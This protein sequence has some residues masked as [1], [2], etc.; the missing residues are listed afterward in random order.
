MHYTGPYMHFYTST[1]YLIAYILDDYYKLAGPPIYTQ[2]S[3]SCVHI[4]QPKTTIAPNTASR[5]ISS[6]KNARR[7]DSSL[8]VTNP[9]GPGNQDDDH[10]HLV[11]DLEALSHSFGNH[12]D[13][14]SVTTT[15]ERD[16][17][18]DC[19]KIV[20]TQRHGNKPTTDETR[21]T[22]ASPTDCVV[23][24]SSE[25]LFSSLTTDNSV[26][27]VSSSGNSYPST[28]AGEVL[29]PSLLPSCEP[30][31]SEDA[32]IL[33]RSS[34]NQLRTESSEIGFEDV[35]L[36]KS[37]SSIE[38]SDVDD[39]LTGKSSDDDSDYLSNKAY[40]RKRQRDRSSEHAHAEPLSKRSRGNEAPKRRTNTHKSKGL[41]TRSKKK[42]K[43][44]RKRKRA[45]KRKS[46]PSKKS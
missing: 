43:L 25:E 40:R 19:V 36:T 34:G 2:F 46:I 7:N 26:I 45:L 30:L 14:S 21:V 4:K 35:I 10:T 15:L 13:E 11:I 22:G 23:H 12:D 41:S 9:G 5:P 16:T 31:G 20:P 27:I 32:R 39:I 6:D 18:V 42:R 8:G 37:V 29:A 17:S 38:S 24:C 3:S 44:T 33:C 28:I 1:S